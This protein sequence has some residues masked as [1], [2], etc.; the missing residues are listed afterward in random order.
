VG[1][2]QVKG[3]REE[4]VKE[5]LEERERH[6]PFASL[7]ELLAR[8]RL[9][10]PT[11]EA[12]TTAGAFDLWAPDGD[13]TR[14]LWTPLGGV[15]PGIRP[16][17]TDPFERAELELE[18]LGLTLE[19]HPAA[20]AR[21]RHGGGSHRAVHAEVPGRRLR[22]WALVVADKTVRTEKGEAMQFITFEDE[23]ALCEAVAFPDAFRKRK[24]P[25]RVGEV[26]PVQGKS[27]RQ[28]GLVVLEVEG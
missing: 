20:L 9:S 16:R 26:V 21:M 27:T 14:L 24:R 28:D 2:M 18:T 1:L 3:A 23:T 22:F 12:L 25:Y 7:E 5:L 17:P 10:L 4:E 6:G 11:V 15:P 8:T 19:I 13:R